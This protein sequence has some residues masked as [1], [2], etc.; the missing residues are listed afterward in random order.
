MPSLVQNVCRCLLKVLR[1]LVII[2]GYLS[3]AWCIYVKWLG[4]PWTLVDV[5]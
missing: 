1:P 3:L 5:M 2:A 4:M